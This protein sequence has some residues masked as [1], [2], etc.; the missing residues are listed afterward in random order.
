MSLPKDLHYT[1]EHEWIRVER[2]SAFVGIT[3]FAQSEL[4][5]IVFVELPAIGKKIAT[6]DSLCVVESTKAASD[7]YAPIGGVVAEVNTKLTSNPE[8]VNSSPYGEGWLVRI[9]Q[10]N[11]SEI[12]ELLS[13]DSYKTLL[14][15]KA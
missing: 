6:H 11:S 9:E 15:D 10:I 7:V 14:G 13:A 1:K 2:E 4:G 5:D 3:E 12:S 8:L